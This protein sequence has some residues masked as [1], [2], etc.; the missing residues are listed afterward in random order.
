MSHSLVA[1]DLLIRIVGYITGDLCMLFFSLFFLSIN[2]R[3]GAR[4]GSRLF[5]IHKE[6]PANQARRL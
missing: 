2:F 5:G 1:S 6:T 3:N 4:E